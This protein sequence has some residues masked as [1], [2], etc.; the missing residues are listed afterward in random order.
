MPDV[1][2]TE[3]P[4]WG[5]E[6]LRE[7]CC[8]ATK[9]LLLKDK[10]MASLRK[11][12]LSLTL[13]ITNNNDNATDIFATQNFMQ[14][15]LCSICTEFDQVSDATSEIDRLASLDALI[16]MLG[17]TINLVEK[18]DSDAS[19]LDGGDV[20]KALQIFSDHVAKSF[21]V[22]LDVLHFLSLN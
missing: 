7:I 19:V 9:L 13:N 20:K 14:T 17:I 8:V 11:A 2:G 12:V 1:N 21:E 6:Y 10:E 15:I 5:P 3:Q 22:S 18:T 4:Q 16:L